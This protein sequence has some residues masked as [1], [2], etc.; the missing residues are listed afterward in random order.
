MHFCTAHINL[1][2]DIA[3]VVVRDEFNPVSW[4]EIEVIR[5]THGENAVSKAK[6]FVRVKQ[7]AKAEKERLILIYG[8]DAVESVFPGRNP[9][10]EMEAVD[11]RLPSKTPEWGAPLHFNK[12]D[13][14]V[15]A[16]TK[17]DAPKARVLTKEPEPFA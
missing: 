2:G 16:E 3:Q 10:M 14:H 4:P 1:A 8:L 17:A 7:S 15:E 12:E 5:S 13:S 11:T 6:P 9:Q